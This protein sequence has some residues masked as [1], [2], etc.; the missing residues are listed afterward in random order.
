MKN[1]SS[2]YGLTVETPFCLLESEWIYGLRDVFVAI[3]AE[4][5]RIGFSPKMRTDTYI[6]FVK[7][8]LKSPENFIYSHSFSLHYG[9]YRINEKVIKQHFEHI[10][11]WNQYST[12]YFHRCDLNHVVNKPKIFLTK[13]LSKSSEPLKELKPK[14]WSLFCQ[15]GVCFSKLQKKHLVHLMFQMRRKFMFYFSF[16]HCL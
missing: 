8:L 6:Y 16:K 1:L 13:I 9:T 4:L 10:Y 3:S 7:N 14:F 5:V 15:N 2:A 11:I 12:Y